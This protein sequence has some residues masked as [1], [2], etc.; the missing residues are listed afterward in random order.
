M[1]FFDELAVPD[2]PRYWIRRARVL[3]G[4]LTTPLPVAATDG[5]GAALTDILVSDG[6]FEAVE[7][8]GTTSST[9][10]PSVDMMGRQV[11]PTLVDMH[12]HI[13]KG[14]IVARIP[15][16]DISF[17][18]A[19]QAVMADRAQHWNHDDIYRRMAFAVRCAYVHGTSAIRTHIDSYEGVAEASWQVFTEVRDAWRDRVAVQAV[20]SVPI[21][22]YGTDYG[23]RLADLTAASGGVLGG[24]TRSSQQ[25]DSR[26]LPNIDELL[27]DLFRLAAERGLDID[28]HVDE[29]DDPAA[30][31]LERVAKAVLR[32]GFK[33]RVVCGHC[34]SLS[35][36]PEE[37]VR[38]TLA[39]CA[40]AGIAVA[41]M[42]PVNL[43]FHD[44][45]AGRTPRWR[46][47][48][49]VHELRAAGI[50]VAVASDNIRDPF[51]PFGDYDMLDVLRQSL[52]IAH[53]DHDLAGAPLMAGRVPADIIGVAPIGRI[54][55]GAPARLILL[56]ARSLGEVFSRPQADRIVVDR[57][58]R[59]TE[60]LPDFAEL[61]DDTLIPGSG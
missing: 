44:R 60:P 34:C 43:Y 32:H 49:L 61:D 16:S 22:V 57:G 7:P 46:G 20:A 12:T 9:E 25:H 18:R 36:Q 58:R 56:N 55:V 52:Y 47:I 59:V 37:L 54:E 31:S 21:D 3:P 2:A 26:L 51:H 48:T 6:K 30:S 4:F 24:V 14:Q 33:G 50:P 10:T 29:T 15:P 19:R 5:D 17:A 42:A 41:C 35:V 39:L 8:A 38:R 27:D 23:R 11:W 28:L 53:L 13:D 45:K 1:A 40:E